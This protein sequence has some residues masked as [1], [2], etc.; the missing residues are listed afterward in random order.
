M[1]IDQE[2]AVIG[3]FNLDERSANL[4]TDCIAVIYDSKI[5]EDLFN[6]IFKMIDNIAIPNTSSILL[7]VI[8]ISFRYVITGTRPSPGYCELVAYPQPEPGDSRF[9]L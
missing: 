1:V 6:Y 9:Y 2:I 4:N 3:M 5:A 8:P 7:F